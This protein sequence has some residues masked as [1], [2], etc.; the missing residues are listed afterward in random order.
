FDA[1]LCTLKNYRE[2]QLFEQFPKLKDLKADF[3]YGLRMW[4]GF[5]KLKV[6]FAYNTDLVNVF[7][8]VKVNISLGFD[9]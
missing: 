4:L 5:A 6:D 1:G 8:P 2:L 9:Y 7:K 3:G